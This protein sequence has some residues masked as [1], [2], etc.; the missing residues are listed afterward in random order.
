LNLLFCFLSFFFFLD[1]DEDKMG[2][3]F[4]GYMNNGI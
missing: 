3:F 1:D 2:K 4:Y